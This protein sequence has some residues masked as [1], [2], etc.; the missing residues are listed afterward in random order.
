M[1][2]L[3]TA[4]YIYFNDALGKLEMTTKFEL[5]LNENSISPFICDPTLTLAL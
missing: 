5:Y 3:T 4:K 1:R 2:I